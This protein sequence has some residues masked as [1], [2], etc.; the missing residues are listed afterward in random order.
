MREIMRYRVVFEGSGG[1]GYSAY[2]PDLPV[3]VVVGGTFEETKALIAEA[4]G[5]HLE[6]MEEEGLPIPAP[7]PA[8]PEQILEVATVQGA[9]TTA[10]PNPKRTFHT[11]YVT[12]TA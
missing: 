6:L 1:E 2:V 11:R 7:T 3:R 4:V 9:P 5:F 12:A 8:I 10:A